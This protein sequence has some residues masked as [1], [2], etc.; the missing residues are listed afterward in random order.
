MQQRKIGFSI[1]T[2]EPFSAVFVKNK[3]Y[4][5]SDVKATRI[6]AFINF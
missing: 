2:I 5:I 4:M 3:C 1:K 6:N